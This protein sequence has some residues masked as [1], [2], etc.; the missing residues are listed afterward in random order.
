MYQLPR[1]SLSGSPDSLTSGLLPLTAHG[2]E[3]VRFLVTGVRLARRRPGQRRE[4]LG[5]VVATVLSG[6]LANLHHLRAQ[7]DLLEH[8]VDTEHMRADAVA[9]ETLAVEAVELGG[10]E[11]G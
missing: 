2:E 10:V 11:V 8:V 5:L 1:A 4:M 7:V 9:L 3:A 6:R